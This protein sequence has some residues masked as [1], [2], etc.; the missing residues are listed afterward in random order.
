MATDEDPVETVRRQLDGAHQRAE[1]FI[2]RDESGLSAETD[3]IDL[4]GELSELINVA[5]IMLAATDRPL[6]TDAEHQ[7]IGLLGRC[8]NLFASSVVGPDRT[9]QADCTEFV[10]HI[11][12]LQHMVMAQAAARAYPDQYRLAGRTLSDVT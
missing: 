1:R 11:H 5:S 7:L 3:P 8:W 2:R 4:I 6:L 10:H 12:A 9:A